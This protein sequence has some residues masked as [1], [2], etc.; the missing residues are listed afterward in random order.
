[1]IL[2]VNPNIQEGI[3]IIDTVQKEQKWPHWEAAE[4][5]TDLPPQPSGLQCHPE[6]TDITQATGKGFL[7]K[8]Q[9][10][11]GWYLILPACP[12]TPKVRV[13]SCR[14]CLV[15]VFVFK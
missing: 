15:C 1:M 10:P 2:E 3:D 13:S 14:G 11:T 5:V 9:M 7:W 4:L 6:N 12:S 8:G